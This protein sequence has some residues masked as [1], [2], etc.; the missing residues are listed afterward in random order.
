[1]LD[2]LELLK[3]YLYDFLYC[4]F[5][6]CRIIPSFFHLHYFIPILKVDGWILDKPMPLGVPVKMML[7]GSRMVPWEA[8]GLTKRPRGLVTQWVTARVTGR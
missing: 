7:S 3:G 5:F 6:F 8:M 4:N 2:L 1:M